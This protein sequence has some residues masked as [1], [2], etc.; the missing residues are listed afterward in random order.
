M[1]TPRSSTFRPMKQ[2]RMPQTGQPV[3][4]TDLFA[5]YNL[6]ASFAGAGGALVAGLPDLLT[7]AGL[8]LPAGIRLMFGV[9][10]VVAL[11]VALLV[12][13]LSP[14]VEPTAS[15]ARNA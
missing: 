6:V 13:R 7:H 12:L 3:R 10:T 14:R 1:P 4:H 8:P 15:V 2:A 9:Y 5:R 11:A